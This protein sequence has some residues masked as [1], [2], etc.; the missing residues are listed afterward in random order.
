MA[1][2]EPG[3][4]ASGGSLVSPPRNPAGYLA[5]VLAAATGVIHLFLAPQ[6]VGFSRTLG[7]LFA[8]NGLGFLGGTAIYLT[9]YW[10]RGLFLVAAGYALVTFVAFFVFG[11]FDGFVSAFYMGGELNVMAVASKAVEALLVVVTGYLYT[12]AEG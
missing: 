8:L 11:G 1:R 4:T 6:V 3:A 9:R 5:I 12:A 10:R 7:V 2:A